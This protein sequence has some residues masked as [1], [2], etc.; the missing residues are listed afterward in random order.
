MFEIKQ[1]KSCKQAFWINIYNRI[2][3]IISVK[4]GD[5]YKKFIK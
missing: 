3:L 5:N 2:F 1:I 4:R